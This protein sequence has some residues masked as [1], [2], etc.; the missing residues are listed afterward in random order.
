M[1]LRFRRSVRLAPGLRLNFSGG[2]IS[3]STGA[4][5]ASVT[6]GSRGTFLNS[7]IP[8]TGIYGRSRIGSAASRPATTPGKVTVGATIKVADD[9]T[10]TY[11]DENGQPLSDYLVRLAKRQQ[12]DQI[13]LMLERACATINAE[14]EALAKIHC[15]TPAPT[16]L[17]RYVAKEFDDPEPQ[18]PA[19]KAVGLLDWLLGKRAQIEAANIEALRH[20]EVALTKWKSAK[21]AFDA[22]E[23]ENARV[24]DQRL[25]SDTDFMQQVLEQNLASLVWPRETIASFEITDHGRTA[26]IDID[27]PEI[28]DIQRKTASV[29]DRGYKLTLKDVKGKNLQELY[30]QHVH[31][32]GFRIAG[33][34]FA[35]LPTVQLLALSGYTQRSD[36]GTGHPTDT[37]VYSVRIAR[38]SWSEINFANLAGID[39]ITAFE[40][41][42]LRRKITR[43]GMLE[44]I[45]PF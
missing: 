40:R 8:G 41:F 32:V 22:R 33:E 12:G 5:G 36:P 4:P 43:S 45:E 42:E 39:V 19:P 26:A 30:G 31:G 2:G 20:H 35:S 13:R 6:F 34:V 25:Q 28:E 29:P 24:F 16:E 37:Y 18:P 11:L 10:I 27:L 38:A 44:A 17:P 14:T 7:G 23:A 3:L 21:A 1:G 9:G 15:Q